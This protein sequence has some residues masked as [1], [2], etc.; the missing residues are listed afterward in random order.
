MTEAES[1][2][3]NEL[4]DRRDGGKMTQKEHKEWL[5]LVNKSFLEGLPKIVATWKKGFNL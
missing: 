1:K 2:R 4:A 5:K 3:Y